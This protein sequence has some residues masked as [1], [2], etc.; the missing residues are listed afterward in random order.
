MV[1]SIL[2][3][4]RTGGQGIKEIDRPEFSKSSLAPTNKGTQTVPEP[5]NPNPNVI[6]ESTGI[7]VGL[8]RKIRQ[9]QALAAGNILTKTGATGVDPVTGRFDQSKVEMLYDPEKYTVEDEE[10]LTEDQ[11]LIDP[12]TLA[13]PQDILDVQ[14]KMNRP[15]KLEPINNTR[16]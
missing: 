5:Q 16:I 8:G 1:S 6:D 3:T 10:L 13:D 9:Q 14:Q 15:D 2:P 12:I 4:P 7:N 11:K